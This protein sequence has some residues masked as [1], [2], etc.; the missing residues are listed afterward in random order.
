MGESEQ[1]CYK[2]KGYHRIYLSLQWTQSHVWGQRASRR[3][4]CRLPPPLMYHPSWLG[5]VCLPVLLEATAGWAKPHSPFLLLPFPHPCF[6]P[7]KVDGLRCQVQD[8]NDPGSSSLE[9]RYVAPKTLRCWRGINHSLISLCWLVLGSLCV[10]LA[11][12]SLHSLEE[13][14]DVWAGSKHSMH[15]SP[16]R[17]RLVWLHLP[18]AQQGANKFAACLVITAFGSL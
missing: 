6:F 5:Y 13:G 4:Y 8:G 2:P 12:L 10:V 15:P 1:V 16:L 7:A 9:V 11:A 3:V 14:C 18:S 17:A